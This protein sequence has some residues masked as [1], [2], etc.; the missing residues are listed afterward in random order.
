MACVACGAKGRHAGAKVGSHAI[1]GVCYR[2]GWRFGAPL[3]NM[4]RWL[5]YPVVAPDGTVFRQVKVEKM[6]RKS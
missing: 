5:Y 3:T 6:R 4:V 1:C 2:E